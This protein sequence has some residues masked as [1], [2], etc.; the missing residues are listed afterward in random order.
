MGLVVVT[1]ALSVVGC[2]RGPLPA[3][4]T[5]N[6][7]QAATPSGDQQKLL[8][9]ILKYQQ[10]TGST[11]DGLVKEIEQRKAQEATAAGPSPLVRDLA[12]ARGL[13]VAVRRAVNNEDRDSALRYLRRLG[14]AVAVLQGET[15]A[16]LICTHLERADT[17][18]LGSAAGVEADVASASV[19]A[20]MNVALKS[21]DAP[22]V[23]NIN[24]GPELEK[25]KARIDKGEYKDAL[26]SIE[27][28]IGAVLSHESV[29]AL[30]HAAAGVRGARDAMERDAGLVVL[31]ELDQLSDGLNRF[32]TSVRG[33]PQA[34]PA[35]AAGEEKKGEAA[36]AK[37]EA[38]AEEK[39]PAEAPAAAAN[40]VSPAAPAAPAANG[41]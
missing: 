37:G 30:E 7:T 28:F 5:S 6:S 15:P 31:A 16:A 10:A 19:L 3:A 4:G 1:L 39:A 23:P 36:P 26:K 20:A 32:S 17:A 33:Q 40:E 35:A 29:R 18:L 8:E 38:K 11:I 25:V 34:E 21:P 13:L 41:M 2:Q 9:D 12:V 24:L 14:E 22:L 27:G